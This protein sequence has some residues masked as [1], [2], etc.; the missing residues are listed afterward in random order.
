[1]VRGLT[2]AE[3][4]VIS[5]LLAS[6]RVSERSRLQRAGVPRS[7]FHAARRRAYQEGWLADRF[8]PNPVEF[9]L[10]FASFVLARPF[11][12]QVGPFLAELGA[13]PAIVYLAHDAAV[14][15]AIGWHASEAE[16]RTA[17]QRATARGA[18]GTT[19]GLVADLRS[20][21]VPVYFDYEGSFAHFGSADGAEGYPT[22]LGGAVPD[23]RH[24]DPASGG[25]RSS[26]AVVELVH[27]PFP[28][29]SD[30]RP[31]HLVGPF[32]LPWGQQKMLNAGWVRHRVL[33]DP[34]R[35]PPFQGRTADQVV[36]LVGRFRPEAR[37]E[38]LFQALT[39]NCRVFPFLFVATEGRLLMGALGQGAGTSEGG[40]NE[41]DRPSIL[42]TVQ[43]RVEGIE[44]FSEPA[45]GFRVDTNH[46]YDR[47]FVRKG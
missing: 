20:P 39:R 23:P 12:D 47:L 30:D 38:E 44:I 42:R 45:P 40:P 19:Y 7:T 34:A 16:A 10:P 33:L 18:A 26:W 21:T 11:A 35:L 32:G 43:Q 41:P 37:P 15:V 22:G 27:R 2:E 9:D 24:P 8:I 28:R 13:D 29:S 6:S 46:R 3:A 4:K 25:R 14:T 36:F 17:A 31:P 1:M 5:A